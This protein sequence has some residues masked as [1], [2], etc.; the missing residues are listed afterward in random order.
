MSLKHYR[1]FF[2]LGIVQLFSCSSKL[3]LQKIDQVFET[4]EGSKPDYSLS[5]NW[6]AL[7]ELSDNADRVPKHSKEKD[8]QSVA[9]ADV[10]F[11]HPTT[12]TRT[13]D[14]SKDWNANIDDP[15]INK[16]T[17]QTT[18]LYQSSTFNSSARVFAPRYRQANISSYFTNQASEANEAFDLAYTDVK[19]A[20]EYYLKNYNQGRPIIIASHSQGTTHAIRL[21]KE[22]FDGKELSKQLVAAYLVGMPVYDSVFTKLKPCEDSTETGCYTSWRTYAR[23]FYPEGYVQPLHPAICT[24]PLSWKTD[25]VNIPRELN[26]G[27]ILKNFDRIVEKVCDA[28]VDIKDGV[29]R[30]SRPHFTGSRLYNLKNYHIADFNLFYMSIRRN[31]QKRIA[32]FLKHPRN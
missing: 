13:T 4:P 17:D 3:H 24:N 23:D 32:E 21:L 26:P 25:T 12:Y 18:I 5:K 22:Y 31:A 27:T 29:L 28:Q 19:S 16:R 2:L 9:Q 7:P 30:I 6:A 15:E 14:H 20:F 11:I 10:F 1:L 8:L